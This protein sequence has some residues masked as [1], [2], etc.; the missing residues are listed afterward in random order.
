MV[1]VFQL[2]IIEQLRMENLSKSNLMEL[3]QQILQHMLVN[4]YITMEQIREQHKYHY[5]QQYGQSQ[6]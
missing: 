4:I 1:E 6:I 5:Q 3:Q 2:L